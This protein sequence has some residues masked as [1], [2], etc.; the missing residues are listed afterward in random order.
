MTRIGIELREASGTR[1]RKRT[2]TGTW[3]GINI[4]TKKI[5]TTS[6]GPEIESKIPI[7]TKTGTRT[8]LGTWTGTIIILGTETG[9][10][11]V[12][13]SMTG[14]RHGTVTEDHGT[15]TGILK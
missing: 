8:A 5:T 11:P 4:G 6:F 7:G 15:M 13:G 9:L 14:T 2:S 12:R 10:S 3:I 1:T